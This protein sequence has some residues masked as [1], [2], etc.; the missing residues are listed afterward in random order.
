M[1]QIKNIKLHIVTDI[2]VNNHNSIMAHFSTNEDGLVAIS[3]ANR[4]Q[5]FD[6]NTSSLKI[7][8]TNQLATDD[9]DSNDPNFIQHLFGPHKTHFAAITGDKKLLIWNTAINGK[10]DAPIVFLLPKR[11]T[12]LC[13]CNKEQ[14]VLVG[15]KMGDVYRCQFD[16]DTRTPELLLGHLSMVLDVSTSYDDSFVVSVDRDEKIRVSHY[17]NAYNILNYCPGHLQLVSTVAF[18]SPDRIVSGSGDAT[19]RL[20]NYKEGRELAQCSTDAAVPSLKVVSKV[21]CFD[22]T[23]AV[24]GE[25]CCAIV[26]Y[27]IHGDILKQ[28]HVH[29]LDQQP[30]DMCFRSGNL[31]VLV[32]N[33]SKPVVCLK[34]V[35]GVYAQTD[36]SV[37]DDVMGSVLPEG[38]KTYRE[39]LKVDAMKRLNIAITPEASINNV[40]TMAEER[41]SEPAIPE[42]VSMEA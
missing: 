1:G 19:V 4:L 30:Y 39:L 20:W 27:R 42:V 22:D 9:T 34:N 12:C 17:P 7:H 32:N 38:V 25:G 5:L 40:V 21:C 8:H 33:A 3:L 29:H 13:F 36:V 28:E 35:G 11:P 10:G 31:L 23:I 2:K 15:D 16:K 6:S 37:P 14:T 18:T 26:F 24:L 41:T